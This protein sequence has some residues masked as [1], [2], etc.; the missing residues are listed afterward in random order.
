MVGRRVTLEM[1]LVK[2]VGPVRSVKPGL[3][4]ARWWFST[5]GDVSFY[6]L[7]NLSGNSVNATAEKMIS[8]GWK[9]GMGLR[10]SPRPPIP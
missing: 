7:K 3:H 5:L 8:S 4:E 2:Q 9:G 1:R 6:L 10:L